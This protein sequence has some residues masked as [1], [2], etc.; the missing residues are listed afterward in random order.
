MVDNRELTGDEVKGRESM[1]RNVTADRH[2]RFDLL[3][4]RARVSHLLMIVVCPMPQTTEEVFTIFHFCSILSC[5]KVLRMKCEANCLRNVSYMLWL[6]CEILH[7][8]FFLVVVSY[9][10]MNLCTVLLYLKSVTDSSTSFYM[11]Q[12]VSFVALLK[13]AL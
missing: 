11:V 5:Q 1:E 7:Y 4:V 8:S 10:P 13:V 2:F 12:Y 3:Q 9:Y 6:C